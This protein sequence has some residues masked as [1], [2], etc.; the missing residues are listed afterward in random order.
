MVI[1]KKKLCLAFG[2]EILSLFLYLEVT[3]NVCFW[4]PQKNTH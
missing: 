3:N 4:A 2:S 1:K